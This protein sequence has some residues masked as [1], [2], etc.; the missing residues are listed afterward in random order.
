LDDTN[1]VTPSA[2]RRLTPRQRDVLRVLMQGKSNKAIGRILNLAEPT[3]KNHVAAIFKALEVTS[4][5]EAVTKLSRGSVAGTS[6]T[7]TLDTYLG[8]VPPSLS[9]TF[10]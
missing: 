7:G 4:R 9:L 2:L 1:S 10:R 5:T 3:V 6:C 8:Y